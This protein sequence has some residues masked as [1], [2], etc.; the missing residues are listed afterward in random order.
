MAADPE[1][2]ERGRYLAV[3]TGPHS[4]VIY[5]AT[6]LCETCSDCDCGEQQDPV[7]LSP[8]GIMKLMSAAKINPLQVLGMAKAGRNGG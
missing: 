6:G 4:M 3:R 2:S 1:E 8:G 7:D 5:R